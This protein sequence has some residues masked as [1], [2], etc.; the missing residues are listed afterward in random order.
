[1]VCVGTKEKEEE[2]VRE[3]GGNEMKGNL[4]LGCPEL[5]L[6][7]WL[8]LVDTIPHTLHYPTPNSSSSSSSSSSSL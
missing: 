7:L 3:S 2:T 1:M 4:T 6:L 8:Q 5:A